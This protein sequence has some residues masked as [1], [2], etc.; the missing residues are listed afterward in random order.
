VE[1][2]AVFAITDR[3]ASHNIVIYHELV[4]GMMPS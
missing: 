3:A 2:C 4:S 1:N